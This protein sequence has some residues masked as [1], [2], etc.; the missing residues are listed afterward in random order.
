[1]TWTSVP[2]L[3]LHLALGPAPVARGDGGPPSCRPAHS[4]THTCR[5][6]PLAPP[7]CVL[8]RVQLL[9]DAE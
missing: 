8:H 2:P 1:M 3:S 6:H 4:L 7:T 5:S 9:L